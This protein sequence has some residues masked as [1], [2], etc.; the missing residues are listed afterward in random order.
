MPF[1]VGELVDLLQREAGLGDAAVP[2]RHA[3]LDGFSPLS[4]TRQNTL[5]WTRSAENDWSQIKA[6]AVIAPLGANAPDGDPA[7]LAVERPRLAF[8]LALREFGSE[9][10]PTGVEPTAMIGDG[11]AIAEDAY[12]GGYTTIGDGVEVGAG[13]VIK[14]HVSIRAGT[15]IG[16]GCTIWP[17]VVIGTDGFGYEQGEDG[18]WVKLE[19][20]G[21]VVIEDGVE[22]GANTC[23]DRGVLG[24]T[25]IRAG[26]KVDNLCHIA[27]NVEVGERA[28]VIALSMVG[29]STKL[30]AESWTAPGA[31]IKNGLE[32]GGGSLVGLGA[33]VLK[34]VA[35]DDVVAGLPA[36]SIKKPG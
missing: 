9:P 4:D 25:T 24:D 29:G 21:G 33:V 26:A 1:T 5:T 32:V 20:Q 11:A 31:V 14:D 27:H 13:T 3:S 8:A 15:R 17:G 34:D 28:M 7:V 22:I 19:H 6:A 10:R 16:S 12:I 36:K 18:E 2:D 30:G 23:V 35:A